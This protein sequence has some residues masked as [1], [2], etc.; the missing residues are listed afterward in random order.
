M[1]LGIRYWAPEGSIAS[2][3]VFDPEGPLEVPSAD[4][5]LRSMGL[6]PIEGE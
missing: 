1:D 2:V 4:D 3:V 6:A 5:I